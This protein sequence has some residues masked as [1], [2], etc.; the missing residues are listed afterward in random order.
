MITQVFPMESRRRLLEDSKEDYTCFKPP[1]DAN[2]NSSQPTVSDITQ[3]C[4]KKD[5][6]VTG[7]LADRCIVTALEIVPTS[8]VDAYPVI[9]QDY[10]VFNPYTKP[11]IGGIL[12]VKIFDCDTNEKINIT[13]QTADAIKVD[14][15]G[16][17]DCISFDEN[18][19][20]FHATG[21]KTT[22]TR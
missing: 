9:T 10:D 21:I 4:F 13:N 15:V 11:S 18:S 5:L 6:F 14:L 17:D 1:A 20:S 2:T 22:N 3:A 19:N 12:R 16:G 7:P 8:Y